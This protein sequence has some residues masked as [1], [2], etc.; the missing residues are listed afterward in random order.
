MGKQELVPHPPEALRYDKGLGM[1]TDTAYSAFGSFTK[2]LLGRPIPELPDTSP[3]VP[4][5]LR[6]A[7][8]EGARAKGG[9]DPMSI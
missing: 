9:G 6:S 2:T 3:P 8:P 5:H 4:L 7:D 1:G